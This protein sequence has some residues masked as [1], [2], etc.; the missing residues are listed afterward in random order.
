M[1]RIWN[2]NNNDD[3][4]GKCLGRKKKEEDENKIFEKRTI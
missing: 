4:L 1:I 3:G 2:W